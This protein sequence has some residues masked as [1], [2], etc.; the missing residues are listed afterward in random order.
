MDI[1]IFTDEIEE[2]ARNQLA[3]LISIP[4]FENK[5]IRIMPDVHAGAGCVIGFTANLGNKIIPNIVGV[6]IGCGMLT[7]DITY[8]IKTYG[9]NPN[10]LEQIISKRIPSGKEIH[11]HKTDYTNL[12]TTLHC[13]T[14]LHK[15]QNL[16]K[17]LGTLGGGNHFIEIDYSKDSGRYFLIIHTGS[18]NLGFQVA[19][20]YQN[21]AIQRCQRNGLNEQLRKLIRDYKEAGRQ[22]EIEDAIITLKNGYNIIPA[23]LC[24]LEGQDME[25]YLDDMEICQHWARE[26]R[27]LIASTILTA[28]MDAIPKLTNI[29]NEE[30]KIIYITGK[31]EVV[32]VPY[33]ETIHNY[34]DFDSN[35]VRK[36]AI[37][38]DW[39]E[40]V[41]IPLNMRDGCIVGIGKGNV[42]WNCS[43]PHGAGRLM[44]RSQARKTLALEDFKES[45]RGI[46]TF[47]ICENTIDEAP[48]AYKDAQSIIKKIEPT[49]QIFDIIKP[50][51]NFK[52]RD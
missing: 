13:F 32:K 17:S 31:R 19:S 3:N 7:L 28:Y 33:F 35:I 43:A 22:I 21:L 45:M 10:K 48:A 23:A 29:T 44:S 9:Y 14:K 15:V 36:G 41:L 4:A 47:S 25:D 52:A 11:S 37:S 8:I 2:E 49:V 18:R 40:K 38:A 12:I 46:D 20:Y 50:L 27:L 5:K 1:K 51:Y 24:Y 16:E 34:V 26:N 6:D 42:D 30:E 39:G